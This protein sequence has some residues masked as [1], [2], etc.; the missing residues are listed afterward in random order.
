MR[1]PDWQESDV[2]QPSPAGIAADH[3][4]AVFAVKINKGA[5]VLGS[6]RIQF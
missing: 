5:T 4:D 3:D 6:N 2:L 1:R